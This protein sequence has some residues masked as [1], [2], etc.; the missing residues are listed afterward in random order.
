MFITIETHCLKKFNSKKSS[1]DEDEIFIQKTHDMIWSCHLF[2]K[3]KIKAIKS[4]IFKKPKYPAV[5]S[6]TGGWQGT[7]RRKMICKGIWKYSYRLI[8]KHFWLRL[9]VP[10]IVIQLENICTYYVCIHVYMHRYRYREND[11]SCKL[12]KYLFDGL[13]NSSFLYETT[14]LVYT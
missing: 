9:I 6:I 7:T 2:I 1:F 4:G 5:V 12:G 13:W 14:S 8:L 3:K 11:K 10:L